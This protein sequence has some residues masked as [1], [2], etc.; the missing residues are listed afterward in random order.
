[1]A[2]EWK[3]LEL[4]GP[5]YGESWFVTRPG[6]GAFLQVL[7]RMPEQAAKAKRR[8]MPPYLETYAVALTRDEIDESTVVEWLPFRILDIDRGDWIDSMIADHKKAKHT[9][10]ALLIYP[11][12]D[13]HCPRCTQVHDPGHRRFS[14]ATCAVL[15]HD[16]PKEGV[17]TCKYIYCYRLPTHARRYCPKI[18]L[19]FFSLPPQRPCGR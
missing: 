5:Y 7:N 19:H 18:N 10:N 6:E 3:P 2:S 15:S 8:P 11:S 12:L 4:L 14:E 13:S 16:G 17:V 1:M 9:A